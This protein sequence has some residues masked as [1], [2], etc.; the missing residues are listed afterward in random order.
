MKKAAGLTLPIA[1]LLTACGAADDGMSTE[2]ILTRSAE[3]MENVSSYA[4]SSEVD[5]TMETGAETMDFATNSRMEVTQNPLAYHEVTEMTMMGEA[6]EMEFTSYFH[7]DHGFYL[8]DPLMGGWMQLPDEAREDMMAMA[9]IQMNPEDQ[10]EQ[11]QEHVS[12]IEVETTDDEYI[13]HLSGKNLDV[14][15][16]ME[17]VGGMDGMGEMMDVME[18]V[19]IQEFDYTIHIDSDTFYQTAASI[20]MSM[21]MDMMGETTSMDQAVD[22]TMD[23]FDEIG[24]ITIPPE[25]L[26]EAEQIDESEL[27]GGF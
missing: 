26:E 25:V 22:M 16:M 20:S 13:I 24:E 9:E 7:E 10:L 6:E 17:Q 3:A 19:D 15:E 4:V 23:S 18:D 1:L 12:D 5:Q 11:F 27:E 2:E 21:T 14:E 8:Q